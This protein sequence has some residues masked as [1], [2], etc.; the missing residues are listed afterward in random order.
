MIVIVARKPITYS[1][2][3][4]S[5]RRIREPEKGDHALAKMGVRGMHSIKLVAIAGLICLSVS[6]ALAEDTMGT[7]TMMKAGQVT[8]IMP[9]GIWAP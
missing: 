5:P 4:N 3:R 2:W 8:A 1:C 9:D 6:P 7:M